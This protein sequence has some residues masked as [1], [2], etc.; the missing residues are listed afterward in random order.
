[1]IKEYRVK[2]NLLK[3]KIS[4][5]TRGITVLIALIL[6]LATMVGIVYLLRQYASFVYIVVELSSVILAFILANDDKEYKEFWIVV[7]L[8]LPVF[9]YFLY[10][11][12]GR[13]SINSKTNKRIRNAEH[14][15]RPALRQDHEAIEELKR[16]HPNKV[17]ISRYLSSQ[18]YPLY[19][20][21][22][23]KYYSLG[24][25]FLKDLIE[26]IKKAKKYIFLE[27]FIISG[28]EISGEIA[29]I[30]FQ[31]V[32]EGVE[33]RLIMD[34]FGCLLLNDRNFRNTLQQNGVKFGVFGPIHQE[35]SRLS[36]NFRDHKKIAVIDGNVGYTGGV[37]L[38]D[39]YANK[40]ERFGHWKDSG[41]R[42]EGRAVFSLTCFFMEMWEAI[43]GEEEDILKYKPV[44]KKESPGYVQPYMGGPH[45][46]ISNP[47]ES[48]YTHTIN[49]A[50]DYL[51]ITT[52]YLVLDNKMR[53]D[54]I[55]AAESGVD[56]R[57]ITP[58]RYDKWYVHMVT[59]SNYGKLMERGVRIYE[60]SKGFIHA[61]NII[62][63]DECGICG[64]VNM[65]YRSF[66]LHY[67]CG[68]VINEH[69]A[70]IEMKKDFL[71]TMKISQKVSYEEWKK[72]PLGQKIMQQVLKVFSPML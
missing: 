14:R 66:Y 69:P 41:V 39:E 31:K 7:V 48:T 4:G 44:V 49:K 18:G 34:D 2:M 58:K 33:V 36:F 16:L 5:I 22:D 72:R 6:Q 29:D 55:S 54:I 3:A 45:K 62:T 26:K 47:A 56:V 24:D 32:K 38:A 51:Y 65:D 50:R 61:K 40:I 17:Q 60:Y 27:F 8:V 10:F 67:E 30:L 25:Y 63:D 20:N 9:G 13:S 71:N 12:W 59:Q 37:N 43:T 28:G 21:T 46:K 57:I 53:S 70:V 68:V 19:K 11:M 42:L 52:P 1:M 15:Y 35:V 23:V 64:T